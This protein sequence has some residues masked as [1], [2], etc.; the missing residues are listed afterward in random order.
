MRFCSRCQS[1]VCSTNRHERCLPTATTAGK[2][3]RPEAGL[4][5]AGSLL[6]SAASPCKLTD[7]RNCSLCMEDATLSNEAERA[8]CGAMPRSALTI[9]FNR[10][11]RGVTAVD[12]DAPLPAPPV[13]IVEQADDAAKDDGHSGGTSE[14]AVPVIDAKVVLSPCSW[15]TREQAGEGSQKNGH[16]GGGSE[17]EVSVDRDAPLPFEPPDR[18]EKAGKDGSPSRQA[19]GSE[20]AAVDPAPPASAERLE[21]TNRDREALQADGPFGEISDSEALAVDEEQGKK[22][23]EFAV[24]LAAELELRLQQL[25]VERGA[26]ERTVAG[27][28]EAVQAFHSERRHMLAEMQQAVAELAL[29]IAGRLLHVKISAGDFAVESLVQQVVEKLGV[30]EQVTVRLNPSDLA[31]LHKRLGDRKLVFDAGNQMQFVA[32]NSLKR[33]DCVAS[34]GDLSVSSRLKDK[35]AE[36]RALL[37]DPESCWH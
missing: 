3:G 9:R 29:A 7:C 34:A 31:L 33:G 27:M 26:V 19:L 8:G 37:S 20:A 28:A 2:F 22:G 12:L 5:E 35:L 17:C 25:D 21:M 24:T 14:L 30:T 13:K 10:P 36:I 15:E 18:L 23:R 32:D 16:S 1:V 4:P 11:L 6:Y